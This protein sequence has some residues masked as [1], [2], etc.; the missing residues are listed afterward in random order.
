MTT[1]Q[2]TG[3]IKGQPLKSRPGYY[4]VAIEY[5]SGKSRFLLTSR[6]RRLWTGEEWDRAIFLH[7]WTHF[8]GLAKKA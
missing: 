8:R 1:P 4:E 3:W 7:C 6:K 5:G 2:L